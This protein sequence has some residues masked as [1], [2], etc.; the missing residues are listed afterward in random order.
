MTRLS[1]FVSLLILALLSC[2]RN[3]TGGKSDFKE[4]RDSNIIIQLMS[5]KDSIPDTSVIKYGVRIFPDKQIASTLSEKSK[6]DLWYRMDSSFYLQS[7]SDKQYASVIEPIANGQKN[8]YEYLLIF[9]KIP[10]MDT[11]K[12]LLAFNDKFI[13]RKIHYFQLNAQ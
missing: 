1:V 9:D 12:L 5:L 6:E 2:N 8:N 10:K 7:G 11:K 4:I 3:S 13:S